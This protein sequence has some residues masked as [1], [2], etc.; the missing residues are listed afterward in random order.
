LATKGFFR[1]CRN[2]NRTCR[3]TAL[4]ASF[5]FGL[6]GTAAILAGRIFD[7]RGNRM[8]PTHSNKLGVRY[9][10]YVSHALLQHRKE[11]AGSVARVPAPEIEALVLD[12]LH[13]H[14]AAI[15]EP[16]PPAPI[17]DR[18]LIERH[19]ERVTVKPEALEVRLVSTRKA[20]APA[21]HQPAGAACFCLTPRHHRDRRWQH[22]CRSHGHWS[23][24]GPAV[25]LGRAGAEHRALPIIKRA[26]E[27]AARRRAGWPIRG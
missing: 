17:T 16:E 6:K 20:S 10:Y 5:V 7:D 26:F 15:V 19:V 1:K 8:S 23:R 25:F 9:R 24:Q 2:Q 3:A 27:A 13:R 4:A 14:R 11:Q 22:A 21:A 18:A 12:G